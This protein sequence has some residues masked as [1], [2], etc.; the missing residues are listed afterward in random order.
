MKMYTKEEQN[1]MAEAKEA[2]KHAYSPYS[3]FK[4]GAALITQKGNIYKGANVENASY[5]L[6]ICAER[7][8]ATQAVFHNDLDLKTI[9]IYV[10]SDISFPPCG[11]CRQFL[12]EFSN[13]LQV[14]FFNDKESKKVSLSEL[15]PYSFKLFY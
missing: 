6:C 12:S 2:A 1:L 14:I 8:A 7:N 15:L 13:D 9:A 3:K 5:S 11:A 4:V 10:D